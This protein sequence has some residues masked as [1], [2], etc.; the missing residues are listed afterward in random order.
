MAKSKENKDKEA[1]Q[2]KTGGKPDATPKAGDS[3]AVNKKMAKSKENK[4]KEAAQLKTDEKP[5]AAPQAKDSP[6]EPVKPARLKENFKKEVVPQLMKDLGLKNPMAVPRLVKISLN[7][8]MGEATQDAKVLESAVTEL[9]AISGQKAVITRAKK[10]IANFKLRKGV[11]IGCRVTLRGN[12]MYEFFDRLVN[13]AL[14]RVRDFR[15]LSAKSF[16]GR[17]SYTFGLKE[18]IIFPE[19]N[20]D[21]VEKIKGMN[22]TIVTSAK[23][24]EMALALLTQMGMPIKK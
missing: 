3:A 5:D 20:Y 13:V 23:N 16:D 14:P 15:G 22:I 9:T 7:I 6:A 18:H 4:K 19:I 11:A 12:R 10:S 8:G 2:L 1:A 17:G 24:D 21:K